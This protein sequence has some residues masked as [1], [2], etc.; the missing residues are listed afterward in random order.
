VVCE[1][2]ACRPQHESCNTAPSVTTDYDQ[3]TRRGQIGQ[4]PSSAALPNH[5]F[6]HYVGILVRPPGKA[7]GQ[8]GS[9]FQFQCRPVDQTGKRDAPR[10][11]HCIPGVHSDQ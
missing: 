2:A 8:N 7:L 10:T 6:D 9:F 4:Y 5:V 11:G 1:I 3:L